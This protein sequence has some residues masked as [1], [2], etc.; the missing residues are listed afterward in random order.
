MRVILRT[1]RMLYMQSA[2]GTKVIQ[3]ERLDAGKRYTFTIIDGVFRKN[4]VAYNGNADYPS[5]IKGREMEFLT[6]DQLDI[7]KDAPYPTWQ[8]GDPKGKW[9]D[10][11]NFVVAE[12][13]TGY[14]MGRITND[15]VVGGLEYVF[16]S[17]YK[18][19]EEGESAEKYP[20]KDFYD[21]YK[22]LT[23]ADPEN[24]EVMEIDKAFGKGMEFSAV[25]KTDKRGYINIDKTSIMS[26]DMAEALPDLANHV[27]MSENAKTIM[28]Y[29]VTNKDYI[30]G[31]P[32]STALANVAGGLK[33]QLSSAQILAGWQEIAK[34]VID[35]DGNMRIA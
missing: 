11:L 29:L 15:Y 6:S 33:G 10:K 4:C 5:D 32:K 34:N 13:E 28:D 2:F 16:T 30:N 14:V 12:K 35:V 24:G 7:V 18:G 23:G 22:A 21:A 26:V 8:S 27:E 17:V 1:R 3:K 25:V 31:S 19:G 9:E 20:Q